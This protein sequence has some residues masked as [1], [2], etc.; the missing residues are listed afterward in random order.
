PDPDPATAAAVRPGP[1]HA[2]RA[3]PVRPAHGGAV[4][5]GPARRRAREG[6]RA[7]RQGTVVAHGEA[8]E[9]LAYPYFQ[10][11]RRVGIIP[12][13]VIPVTKRRVGNGPNPCDT[14]CALAAEPALWNTARRYSETLPCP[15]ANTP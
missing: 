15:P 11:T 8:Q 14:G 6:R 2:P 7:D 3:R 13:S 4:R 9:G 5:L 1:G 12:P 10:T